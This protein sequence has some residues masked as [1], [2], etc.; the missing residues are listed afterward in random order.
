[1][2][3]SAR[4]SILLVEDE[5][6]LHDALRLNL[7]LENYQVTSAYNGNE[8]LKA[9]SDEYFDLV[10]LRRCRAS[11]GCPAE[12]SIRQNPVPIL[13]PAPVIPAQTGCSV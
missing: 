4:K 12:P 1:M 2:K 10:I 5:E 6:N 7:E 8:A 9:I 13:I 3:E 11:T